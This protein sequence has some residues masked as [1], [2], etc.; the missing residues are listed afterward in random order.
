MLSHGV[1][2]PAAVPNPQA[3]G[4]ASTY[5]QASST[6]I[7]DNPK[8]KRKGSVSLQ[9]QGRDSWYHEQ[10]KTGAACFTIPV[11]FPAS[12]PP[13]IQQIFSSAS[14]CYTSR[15]C[16]S[17]QNK[18]LI[19]DSQS[20]APVTQHHLG[21][22][23]REL[24]HVFVVILGGIF[25]PGLFAQCSL[26]VIIVALILTAA[27]CFFSFHRASISLSGFVLSFF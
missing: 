21:N 4:I 16:P 10:A 5:G 15:L 12:I 23:S 27:C 3:E 7:H 20:R 9:K 6:A 25:A 26:A 17:T 1:S 14:T 11:F 22:F 19:R 2:S 18:L 24:G 8:G 13:R